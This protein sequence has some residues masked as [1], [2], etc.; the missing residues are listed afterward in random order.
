MAWIYYD[1]RLLKLN[2]DN[3]Y[4]LV[5]GSKLTKFDWRKHGNKIYVITGRWEGYDP[6]NFNELYDN[7]LN[8]TNWYAKGYFVKFIDSMSFCNEGWG[9]SGRNISYYVAFCFYADMKGTWTIQFGVDNGV[10]TGILVDGRLV[11]FTSA[12]IWWAYRWE[13]AITIKLNLDLG[14]H[15]VEEFGIENCCDGGRRYRIIKPDGTIIDPISNTKLNIKFPFI[16]SR[17]KWFRLE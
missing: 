17:H 9:G 7:F 6:E 13:W 1:P 10:A 4:R 3:Y 2:F 5:D 8:H 16:A 12:D 14:W 11:Y 15:T